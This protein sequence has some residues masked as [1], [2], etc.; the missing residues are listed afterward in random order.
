MPKLASHD[1]QR[2]KN[3][4]LLQKYHIDPSKKSKLKKKYHDFI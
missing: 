3:L 4:Q 1:E 2:A